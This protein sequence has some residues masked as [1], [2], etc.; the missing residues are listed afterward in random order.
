MTGVEVESE[1]VSKKLKS[2]P[3]KWIDKEVMRNVGD[4][5]EI[6]RLSGNVERPRKSPVQQPSDLDPSLSHSRM[7]R[8]SAGGLECGHLREYPELK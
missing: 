4:T 2:S 3:N 6:T 1:R 5:P 8:G 7:Y